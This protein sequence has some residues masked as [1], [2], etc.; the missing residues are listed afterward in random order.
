MRDIE[1]L[2]P[3]SESDWIRF[4]QVAKIKQKVFR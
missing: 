1:N 4:K 3:M 2:K